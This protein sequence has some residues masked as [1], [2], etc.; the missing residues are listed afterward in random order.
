MPRYPEVNRCIALLGARVYSTLAQRAEDSGQPLYPLHIGDTYTEPALGCRM[1]DLSV[2]ELPGL[3][4][5]APVAGLPELRQAIALDYNHQMSSEIGAQQVLVT[6]G[7]TGGLS[8]CV[9]ALVE[10][11]DEVL[12]LAP[13]WPLIAGIVTSHSGVPVA[14]AAH[15]VQQNVSGLLERLEAACT[16]RTVALYLNT[17]N[18]PTGCVYSRAWLQAVADWAEKKGLWIFS[19]EVY[20]SYVYEGQHVS[21]RE[22]CPERSIVVHSFSK[23]YGM[24][25]NRVGFL[26]ADAD[27][28]TAVNKISTHT[29]YCAPKASQVAAL[30]ALGGAGGAWVEQMRESYRRTGQAA[31]K[32]LGLAPAQGSTFLF[33]DVAAQLDQRGLLG[34]LQDAADRGVLVAPGASF[35]PGYD[36]Y[37][38]VCFTSAPPSHVLQGVDLLAQLLGR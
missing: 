32:R 5:Y 1:Q 3:H 14:V 2:D 25:G 24:A 23:T 38:R 26:V 33:F 17:P 21:M 6:A 36:T 15:D 18:N 22:L 16:A 34:L 28:I 37:L 4:R 30:R 35:G 13:Y 31:A 9:A 27:V 20:A 29:V 8:A 11:G 12:L 19:D 7:A 10:P